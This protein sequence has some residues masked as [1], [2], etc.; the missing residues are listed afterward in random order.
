LNGAKIEPAGVAVSTA[1]G[2]PGYRSYGVAKA[3][4]ADVN[5]CRL[6]GQANLFR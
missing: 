4:N 2:V 6:Q 5:N 1:T 3:T